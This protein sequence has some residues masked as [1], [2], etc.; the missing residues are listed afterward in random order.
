MRVLTN[1]ASFAAALREMATLAAYE[2]R[3]GALLPACAC[4]WMVVCSGALRLQF[5]CE[6]EIMKIQGHLNLRRSSLIVYG[7]VLFGLKLG[8]RV[9]VAITREKREER[10]VFSLCY[11]DSYFK[12]THKGAGN[13]DIIGVYP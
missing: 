7:F 11:S 13:L 3:A 8:N 1:N 4:V 10:F 12:K 2:K 9:S 6:R 5:N